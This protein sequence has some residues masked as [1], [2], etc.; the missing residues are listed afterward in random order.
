MKKILIPALALVLSIGIFGIHQASAAT[1]ATPAQIIAKSDTAITAR[2]N[3]LNKLETTISKFKH[4]AADQKT[5][6]TA[7]VQSSIDA[8]NTLKTKID[9]ETDLATLKTDYASITKNYRIYM[10]VMPSTATIAAT[11]NAMANI[12]TYLD[13]LT[14]LN[15]RITAAQTAGKNVAAVQAKASDASLKLT[16][17]QSQSQAIITAVTGLKPDMG[18]KT[19]AAN[20]K[21]QLAAAKSARKT[22]LADLATV[23]SDIASIRMGLKTL[24]A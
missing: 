9:G 23:R 18:D 15:T 4:L 14:K 7:T 3:S 24:K 12:T 2:V 20:N 22:L 16:D 6:L 17:A 5:A 21:T 8:M 13:T 1:A 10:L 19:V 11:D